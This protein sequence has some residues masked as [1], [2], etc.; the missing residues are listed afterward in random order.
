MNK[1]VQDFIKGL[2]KTCISRGTYHIHE[3]K[4]P[5]HKHANPS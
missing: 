4:T 3:R 1:T 5:Y 2:E